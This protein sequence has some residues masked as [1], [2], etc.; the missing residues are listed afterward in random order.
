[1]AAAPIKDVHKVPQVGRGGAEEKGLLPS[2]LG[3]GIFTHISLTAEG[4][5]NQGLLALE[6]LTPLVRVEG[7][8][9][10]FR[11]NICCAA[12]ANAFLGFHT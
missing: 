2:G 12:K 7:T 8:L 4:P 9:L 3:P 11:E 5:G 6:R 10:H 1:M